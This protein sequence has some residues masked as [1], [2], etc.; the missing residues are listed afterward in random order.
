MIDNGIQHQVS[1]EATHIKITMF[2]GGEPQTWIEYTTEQFDGLLASLLEQ[3]TRMLPPA[4]P[5]SDETPAQRFRRVVLKMHGPSG[6][7]NADLLWL[8]GLDK[9]DIDAFLESESAPATPA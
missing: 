1:D 4:A 3:R 8:Y 7:S 5:P 6:A 9:E 2:L